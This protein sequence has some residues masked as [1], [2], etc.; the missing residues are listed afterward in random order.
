MHCKD[1]SLVT[2]ANCHEIFTLE[3]LAAEDWMPVTKRMKENLDEI[4][5]SGV[6]NY[7]GVQKKTNNKKK[8]K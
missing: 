5:A 7:R 1:G 6:L 3:N 8:G 2:L 4:H